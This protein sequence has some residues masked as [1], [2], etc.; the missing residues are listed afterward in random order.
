MKEEIRAKALELGAFS[1]GFAK[2]MPVSPK[3]RRIY[4]SWISDGKNGEMA[5][6]ANY[7]EQRND[8]RLLFTPAPKTIIACAFQYAAGDS[9]II[10]SYALCDDYHFTVKNKLRE[11]GKWIED[12]WGGTARA[13]TDSA[14]IRERY[15]AQQAGI[16]F[17]GLNNQLI[18]PGAGSYFFLGELMWSG[19]IEPDSP[20][21]KACGDCM[22][23]V[24]ACPG[25]ALDGFGG[26][27]ARKCVSYLT[28]EHRSSLPLGSNLAGRIYGCDICLKVCPH[29]KG[30]DLNEPTGEI[31][32]LTPDK[33]MQMSQSHYRKMTEHSAMRRAPLKQLQRNIMHI[34]RVKDSPADASDLNHN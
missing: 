4:E 14:P 23:C 33:L 19:E 24:K 21:E 3:A 1:C 18:V 2:A 32:S 29:N 13:F 34:N 31:A 20:C 16:G 30:V 11:L 17:I 7:M 9:P 22:A 5:Y 27:D 25:R 8:P 10:A 26:C 12:A 28:I 15:W 6:C